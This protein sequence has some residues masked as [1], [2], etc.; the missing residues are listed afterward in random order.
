MS[1]NGAAFV[2]PTERVVSLLERS[3]EAPATP[4]PQ[5][6]TLPP[7]AAAFVET[8]LATNKSRNPQETRSKGIFAATERS[9]GSI[10]GSVGLTLEGLTVGKDVAKL[11]R[12]EGDAI[13]LPSPF[14]VS[15]TAAQQQSQWLNYP[16][17]QVTDRIALVAWTA[18][19][20]HFIPYQGKE[21][22]AEWFALTVEGG[23]DGKGRRGGTTLLAKEFRDLIA[24]HAVPSSVELAPGDVFIAHCAMPFHF[25]SASPSYLVQAVAAVPAA[26]AG[27]GPTAWKDALATGRWKIKDGFPVHF[28]ATMVPITKDPSVAPAI[29]AFPNMAKPKDVWWLTG[30][31]QPR[32]STPKG[33]GM[34]SAVAQHDAFLVRI[35]KLPAHGW[36][37]EDEKKVADYRANKLDK[38]AKL[39]GYKKCL[40]TLEK[41][42]Q[43]AEASADEKVP[44]LLAVLTKLRHDFDALVL[45]EAMKKEAKSYDAIKK[46][47]VDIEAA[48]TAKGNICKKD[49]DIAALVESLEALSNRVKQRK[50][51]L[52]TK[53]NRAA[54]SSLP[55]YED[56]L[57]ALD[58]GDF[59]ENVLSNTELGVYLSGVARTLDKYDVM[60]RSLQDD[61][62]TKA[63][64]DYRMMVKQAIDH[65]KGEEAKGATEISFDVGTIEAYGEA[66][67]SIWTKKS[68]APPPSAAVAADGAERVI[69]TA[70]GERIVLGNGEKRRCSGA[71]GCDK[72][73]PVFANGM[74]EK[75]YKMC[76]KERYTEIEDHE[77]EFPD[78]L[79]KKSA[80]DAMRDDHSKL[81]AIMPSLYDAHVAFK[82][83]SSNNL[84][85]L[86]ALMVD[87]EKILKVYF[88]DFGRHTRGAG[89]GEDD[90]E[91]E[92]EFQESD[93][94]EGEEMSESESGGSGSDDDD[95]HHYADSPSKKKKSRVS[96]PSGADT[97]AHRILVAQRRTPIEDAMREIT[98]YY[99][100]GDDASQTVADVKLKE[101]ESLKT[102]YGLT[103]KNADGVVKDWPFV[104][105]HHEQAVEKRKLYQFDNPGTTYEVSKRE[106]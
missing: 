42:I 9:A 43:E 61:R 86:I 65:C 28:F 80:T 87:A 34:A 64:H 97:L 45:D 105:A 1:N 58:I 88:R 5:Q 18:V 100:K 68:Q 89:G 59:E 56:E 22:E 81:E 41:K 23:Q 53:R 48:S 95:D 76:I 78:L 16:H 40:S 37:P 99:L 90:E 12:P 17:Q 4:A 20:L 32:P 30:E 6:T 52:G 102:V 39:P 82:K 27:C 77:R 44:Q 35:S 63:A 96:A 50:T 19:T 62:V 60:G 103:V 54:N 104:F 49:K 67:A 106:L 57:D 21:L 71:E 98:D 66:L 14:F 79:K 31:A 38:P 93:E 3:A 83:S 10:D 33:G 101:L 70:T 92:D 26:T 69:Q 13:A 47:L 8:V 72:I 74:C 36:D 91:E 15:G 2:F 73:R 51:T 24:Q 55:T 75:C 29:P 11:L 25:S 46:K 84:A 85:P 7:T 94:E